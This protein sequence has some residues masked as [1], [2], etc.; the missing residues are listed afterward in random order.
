M[1]ISFGQIF[2]DRGTALRTKVVGLLGLLTLLNVMAWGWA[3]LSFR[4]YPV[5]LGTALI[6]WGFGLRHAVDADHIAAIDNVTRKLMQ[7][8]KRPVAVGFFFSL[9]HSTIVALASIAVAATASAF[10][11]QIEEYHAIGG[12]IGTCVSATFLL[13]IALAN[14]AIFRRIYR[15]FQ[16]VRNGRQLPDESMED[17]LAGGG[18]LTA[19]LRPAFRLVTRSWHMYPLGLLFGLGFDTATE[20]GLLVISAAEAAKGMDVWAIMI[21]PVLFAVGMSLIDTMDSILMLGA[22]GWA[23]VKPIRKLYYNMTIT[24][25]SV[26]VA[27][28]VGGIEALGMLGDKLGLTGPFWEAIGSLNGNFGSIGFVII[29]VFIA[30]WLLSFAI[31]RARGYDDLDTDASAD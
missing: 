28:L 20:V 11:D 5:L 7:A 17:M 16:E 26:V 18:Y 15:T 9:G 1:A 21:F 25:V 30:A 12:V 14:L 23:F 31:Y 29:G 19:V 13:I 2:D 27:L 10:K 22:Y 6:A 3:L 24:G 4:T 8:G